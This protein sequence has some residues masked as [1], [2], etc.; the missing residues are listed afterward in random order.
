[1]ETLRRPIAEAAIVVLLGFL[2]GMMAALIL[3]LLI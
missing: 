3:H 1:M 2:I